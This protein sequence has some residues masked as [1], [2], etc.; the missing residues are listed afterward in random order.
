MY[1]RHYGGVRT[2]HIAVITQHNVPEGLQLET[3][4]AVGINF[5]KMESREYVTGVGER[6]MGRGIS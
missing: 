4:L 2:P 3:S 6:S 5:R 1:V